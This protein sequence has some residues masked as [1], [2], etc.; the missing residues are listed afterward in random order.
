MQK[1]IWL[2]LLMF[3]TIVLIH[4]NSFGQKYAADAKFGL[5]FLSGRGSGS[6]GVLFGGALDI[7]VGQGLYARPELN[8]TTH[9]DTPI[10]LAGGLKYNIPNT[11]T[12]TQFYVDGGIG[13]WF[14]SG[15]PYVGLDFTGGA[16]FPLSDSNLK[17]PA[18]VRI[19]PIFATGSTVFQV[20]LTSGVRFVIP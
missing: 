17:I 18:E 19:G 16:I 5:S 3:L 15:G 10:E 12:A 11:N 8:I 20:T 1:K 6:S 7:P 2:P 4:G 9:S 14:Y 13:I